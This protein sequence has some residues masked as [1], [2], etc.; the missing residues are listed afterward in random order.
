MFALVHLC[1]PRNINSET[2]Y[3]SPLFG[4]HAR[5]GEGRGFGGLRVFSIITYVQNPA[6]I[7]KG[8]L[9]LTKCLEH[10]F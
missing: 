4:T 8:L 3:L 6:S 1:T 5:T 10:L 9:I 2:S 7:S